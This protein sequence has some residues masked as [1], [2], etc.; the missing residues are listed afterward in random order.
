MKT[1]SIISFVLSM[2]AFYFAIIRPVLMKRKMKKLFKKL[3]NE[4]R[5]DFIDQAIKDTLEFI[6]KERTEK[7]TDETKIN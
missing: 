1:L 4:L 7:P 3:E 6:K 5:G 2:A